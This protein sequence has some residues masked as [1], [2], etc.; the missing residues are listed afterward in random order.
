MFENIVEKIV[1][2]QIQDSILAEEDRNIYLYGYQMLIEFCINIITSII[3]AVVFD[4]YLTV[5]VFTV[6]YLMIRGYAGGYHAKSSL[7]CFCMSAAL[8]ILAV[9][10]VANTGGADM[11]NN[12]FWL[13]CIMMPCVIYYMPIPAANKPIT[14]NERRH[15][16]KKIKQIYFMELILELIFLFLK[17]YVCALSILAVH[18]TLFIMVV[19]DFFCKKTK[20][21]KSVNADF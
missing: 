3:I 12:L 1:D 18:I 19:F 10:F 16:K 15:F 11:K 14:E 7:G 20:R 8:L 5:L 4:A 21:G 17:L 6:A 9:V 13:E 2:R